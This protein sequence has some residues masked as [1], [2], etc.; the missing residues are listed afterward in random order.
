MAGAAIWR[1]QSSGAQPTAN[2]PGRGAAPKAHSP[3]CER[4]ESGRGA[5]GVGGACAP[6]A[7]SSLLG[8]PPH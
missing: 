6:G 8:E 4:S 5:V 3:N 2:E 1:S 7:G